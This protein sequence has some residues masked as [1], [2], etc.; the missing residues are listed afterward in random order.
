M[1]GKY[2][3]AVFV[4]LLAV[5]S[6]A[7]GAQSE[8]I[9]GRAHTVNATVFW[10][11]EK[12][13][14]DNAHIPNDASMWDDAWQQHYGGVDDPRRRQKNGGWPAGFRPRENPYYCALPYS[15][16]TSDGKRKANAR[17]LPWYDSSRP[18]VPTE[19][20]VKNRWVKVTYGSKAVY[21]Q[22]EDAGPMYYD[23]FSYVFGTKAPKYKKAGIDLS[24][25]AALYLRID[26]HSK[27]TW[28]FIDASE[29]P[30]GPWK[31]IVTTRQV[32]WK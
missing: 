18:P 6:V 16:F 22:W 29:V 25:A 8:P 26:G 32:F 15:D 14:P 19:S 12:A 1:N 30:D 31:E 24:P 5:A 23:D 7:C 2:V 21:V 17:R 13:T 11:G 3:K 4:I 9:I 28:R 27:V 10:I 20:V